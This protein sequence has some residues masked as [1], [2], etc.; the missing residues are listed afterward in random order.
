M[1]NALMHRIYLTGYAG[2][3]APRWLR[4]ALAR[5]ELHRAWLSGIDGRFEEAGVSYG[6]AN[7]YPV[8]LLIKQSSN[9]RGINGRIAPDHA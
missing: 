5:T 6:P 1:R 3:Q 2:R 7:P 4:R 9:E 8:L